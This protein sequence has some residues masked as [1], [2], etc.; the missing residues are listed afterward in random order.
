MPW[1]EWICCLSVAL[2]GHEEEQYTNYLLAGGDPKKWRGSKLKEHDPVRRLLSH[3]KLRQ[4]RPVRGDVDTL[5]GLR[6]YQRVT[7]LAD[8]RY[9]D[10]MTGKY[11][12]SPP[13]GFVFVESKK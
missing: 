12:D 8:G 2:D 13:P 3:P 9:F 11:F 1:S 7:K 10:T 5:A 4:M 6:G